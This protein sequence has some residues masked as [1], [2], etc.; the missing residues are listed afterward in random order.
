LFINSAESTM[1][2]GRLGEAI[3]LY[4][5]G[6]ELGEHAMR[7]SALAADEQAVHLLG[8]A[9]ALDRDEQI[10][11]SEKMVARALELDS[12]VQRLHGRDNF[13]VPDGDVAYYDALV[14][15][16]R[17]D[18][19]EA[20]SAFQRFLRDVPQSPFAARARAHLT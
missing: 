5:R 16:A 14:A 2:L 11:K 7:A 1:A 13:F 17:G 18:H 19:A 10:E 8:L 9:V 3:E 6:I 4:R 15:L 12:S 20:A